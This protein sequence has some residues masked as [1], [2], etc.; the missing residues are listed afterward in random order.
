MGGGPGLPSLRG[1][2]YPRRLRSGKLVPSC[3]LLPALPGWGGVCEGRTL[4]PR[5]LRAAVPEAEMGVVRGKG[6]PW[7]GERGMAGGVWWQTA[8]VGWRSPQPI[9]PPPPSPPPPSILLTITLPSP[10]LPLSSSPS[11]S[12]GGKRKV[13]SEAEATSLAG[14]AGSVA[15]WPL[16]PEPARACAGPAP[17]RP[18]GTWTGLRRCLSRPPALLT[19]EP[20]AHPRSPPVSVLHTLPPRSLSSVLELSC[21]VLVYSLQVEHLTLCPDLHPNSLRGY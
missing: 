17:A 10:I 14:G 16:C 19:F 21:P 20:P 6:A 11:N 13:E 1:T 18:R 9:F 15:L 8:R 3:H 7:G 5:A 12:Q 4:C 2:P